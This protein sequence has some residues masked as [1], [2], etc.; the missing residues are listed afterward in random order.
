ML[1]ATVR[2]AVDKYIKTGGAKTYSEAVETCLEQHLLP[3]LKTFNCHTF[4]KE[5]L[6]REEIDVLITR[7]LSGL[8]QVY[9]KHS[10]KF[11]MPG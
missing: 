1:E 10:G 9:A 11:A 8:Q 5:K 3:Y 7:L 6:W 2:L 4:R